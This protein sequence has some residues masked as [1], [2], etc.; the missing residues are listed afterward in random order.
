MYFVLNLAFNIKIKSQAVNSTRE[1][2]KNSISGKQ[3]NL[4][5][6]RARLIKIIKNITKKKKTEEGVGINKQ[7]KN[8]F[9]IGFK[10]SGT[11]S[12]TLKVRAFFCHLKKL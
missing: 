4:I 1:K 11:L 12:L 6:G 7:K 10:E 3:L 5:C 9:I 8:N 2:L